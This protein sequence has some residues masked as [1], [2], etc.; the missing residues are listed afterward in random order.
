MKEEILNA[1][2]GGK[3][4]KCSF[5]KKDGSVREMIARMGVKKHLKGGGPS[6]VSHIP[7]YLTVFDMKKEQ[8]RNINIETLQT[9][10]CGE[11]HVGS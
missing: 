3:I 9:F 10:K 7:K 5:V 8:Y 6:S 11:F 2:K 1:I 4:F